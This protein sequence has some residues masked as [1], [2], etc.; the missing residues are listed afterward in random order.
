MKLKKKK[1]KNSERWSALHKNIIRYVL[2]GRLKTKT[3]NN[4]FFYPKD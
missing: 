2:M 3:G 1:N 4:N